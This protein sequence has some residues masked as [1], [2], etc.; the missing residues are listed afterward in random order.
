M[1][2]KI[3]HEFIICELGEECDHGTADNRCTHPGAITITKEKKCKW[4]SMNYE[5]LRSTFKSQE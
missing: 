5:Y 1:A 4:F 2:K 3:K